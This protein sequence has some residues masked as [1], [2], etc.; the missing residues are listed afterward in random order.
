MVLVPGRHEMYSHVA[1]FFV[2]NVQRYS[3][4]PLF[5]PSLFDVFR[6][7]K[8]T[9]PV[10]LFEVSMHRHLVNPMSLAWASQESPTAACNIKF[11]PTCYNLGH[12]GSHLYLIAKILHYRAW[13]MYE[14]SKR[15]DWLR[16]RWRRIY[17][18]KGILSCC[19]SQCSFSHLNAYN[20]WNPICMMPSSHWM[21]VLGPHLVDSSSCAFATHDAVNEFFQSD[22]RTRTEADD[23]GNDAMTNDVNQRPKPRYSTHTHKNYRKIWW[24]ELPFHAHGCVYDIVVTPCE[25]DVTKTCNM[26]HDSKLDPM[27]FGFV[28]CF[29][30]MCARWTNGTVKTY[31]KQ[32]CCEHTN[33]MVRH[34]S[35]LK[36]T[37]TWTWLLGGHRVCH[38]VKK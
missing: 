33:F 38:N 18:I 4:V 10:Q 1:T 26:I 8:Q 11:F 3:S 6:I 25:S 21:L 22:L 5:D 2:D 9:P 32:I 12:F 37:K 16:T 36:T 35:C 19:E 31:Y 30:A 14:H 7:S 15:L 29:L 34:W 13:C 23:G 17:S 20:L 28:M 27:E 24:I